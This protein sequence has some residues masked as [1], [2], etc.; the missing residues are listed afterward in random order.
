[1][2]IFT[3]SQIG[4]IDS[5][6]LQNQSIS[7]YTLVKRVAGEIVNWLTENYLKQNTKVILFA[8]KGN[9]GN[10]AI[11]VAEMLA[12]RGIECR[13]FL[14]ERD[15]TNN[16][17][18][19]TRDALLCDFSKSSETEPVIILNSRDIPHIPEDHL[20]IDG[21]FGTGLS[22]VPN[23]IYREVINAINSS[24]ALVVSIDLPSGMICSNRVVNNGD[25]IIK[26]DY[27]LTLE[28]PK[29]PLFIKEY[30][31]YTGKWIIL[32]IGL[33]KK[34][35]DDLE[36]KNFMIDETFIRSIL[37]KRERHSHKGD[38]GHA[39]LVAGST[40]MAGAAILSAKS[41]LRSGAGLLTTALPA[42]LLM[43]MQ[44]SVP[45]SICHVINEDNQEIDLSKFNAAAIGPGL[46]VSPL[47]VNVVEKFLSSYN[48]PAVIDADAINII[49]KDQRLHAKIP[50]FSIFTPHPGEFAR[51][52]GGWAD[53]SGAIE[54][55]IGFSA[56]YRVIVVLKGAFTSVSTPDGELWF[57]ST[58]NPGMATAGSGDVLTGVILG[59]LAQGYSPKEAA[60]SAVYIHGLAGD[61]ALRSLGEESLIASDIIANLGNAFKKIKDV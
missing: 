50:V 22:G 25:S 54:K 58:G 60:L 53:S 2:K 5:A 57:N 47:S 46:G 36:T 38:Y 20:I 30:A 49:A 40:G 9:N 21:I 42:N 59:L 11:A 29:Y 61:F 16:I 17:N 45:E 6:T 56:K 26:A 4:E 7:E 1:M 3:T 27:T 12:A 8:G 35:M 31:I 44:T 33:D 28:F 23:G 43:I 41:T 14:I 34:T 24:T 15:K 13:L 18:S 55:Q 10:D 51:L 37:K 52:T 19:K 39:L 32:D 48:K